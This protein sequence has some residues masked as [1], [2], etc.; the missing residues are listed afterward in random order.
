MNFFLTVESVSRSGGRSL[1][2]R[3]FAPFD[4]V[5]SDVGRTQPPPPPPSLS[6]ADYFLQVFPPSFR[7][8][9][10]PPLELFDLDEAF[11]SVF[12]KLAQFANKYAVTAEE[13]DDADLEFFVKECGKIVKADGRVEGAANLLHHIGA[14]IAAFKSID[15][16]K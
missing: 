3:H 6:N 14:Q 9:P 10:P 15:T 11:S 1:I 7:E 5:K 2:L 13:A 12:S 4:L 16:I 8:L